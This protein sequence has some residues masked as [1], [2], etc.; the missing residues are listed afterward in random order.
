MP[1]A[2]RFRPRGESTQVIDEQIGAGARATQGREKPEPT[3]LEPGEPAKR[4]PR[5]QINS[6]R[7]R[8]LGADFRIAKNN[9]PHH[10]TRQGHDDGAGPPGGGH[11]LS[12]DRKDP[13]ANDAVDDEGGQTPATDGA[14]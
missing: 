5:V 1:V 6:A 12:R 3:N 13:G 7:F 11:Q 9:H 10:E 4:R 2:S 14:G 8:E